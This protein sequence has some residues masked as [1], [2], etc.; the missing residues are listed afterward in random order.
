MLKNTV[1]LDEKDQEMDTTAPDGAVV[2]VPVVV[3][4]V[5]LVACMIDDQLG[6]RKDTK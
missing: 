2:T 1:V 5:G 4:M 6:K 3:V